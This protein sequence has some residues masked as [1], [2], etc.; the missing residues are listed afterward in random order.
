MKYSKLPDNEQIISDIRS[1]NESLITKLYNM[2]RSE[3]INFGQKHF[4]IKENTSIDIYQESFLALYQNI[5]D[6]KL[7]KL[8]SSLKTYLFQIGRNKMLNYVNRDKKKKL[9]ENNFNST[10]FNL[11]DPMWTRKKEIIDSVLSEMGE[12]CNTVLRLAFWEDRD[13]VYIAKAVGY[14]SKNVARNSKMICIR[15]L[16]NILKHRFRAEGLG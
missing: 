11:H 16:K 15:K 1:K 8:S 14:A 13:M 12:P 9:K 7:T 4:G 2:Y 6:G 10:D 3:F 5:Q